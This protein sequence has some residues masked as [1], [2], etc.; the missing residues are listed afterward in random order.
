[1]LDG[2]F[3]YFIRCFI[4]RPNYRNA[5]N[6]DIVIKINKDIKIVQFIIL[7]SSRHH[8]VPCARLRLLNTDLFI[9]IDR[10]MFID[11]PQFTS[12]HFRRLTRYSSHRLEYAY[13][14]IDVKCITITF[15]QGR[16]GWSGEK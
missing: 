13:T 2:R 12:R 9:I 8:F 10:Q 7:F 1:M 4:T 3:A 6:I 16:G 11:T 14:D 5:K 15:V